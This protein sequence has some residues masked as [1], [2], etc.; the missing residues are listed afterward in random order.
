MGTKIQ[1]VVVVLGL[2]ITLLAGGAEI[3]YTGADATRPAELSAAGNWSGGAV[4]GAE[5]I[6]VIDVAALG[7]DVVELTLAVDWQVGGIRLENNDR[8]L[9]LAPAAG[10]ASVPVLTLGASGYTN[11][12]TAVSLENFE[13]GLA[14]RIPLATACE[15]T[16]DVGYQNF[17]TYATVSGSATLTIAR[18]AF[19]IHHAALEYGGKIVY[20]GPFPSPNWTRT[21]SVRAYSGGRWAAE[22]ENHTRCFLALTN[23]TTWSTLFAN[24]FVKQVAGNFGLMVRYHEDGNP[25]K[26]QG[27]LAFTDGDRFECTGGTTGGPSQ[28]FLD[29]TGG[30]WI[31]NGPAAVGYFDYYFGTWYPYNYRAIWTIDGGLLRAGSAFAGRY[32]TDTSTNNFYRF[33]QRGGDVDLV[34]YLGVGGGNQGNANS[35]GEYILR[36]GVLNI[37]TNAAGQTGTFGLKLMPCTADQTTSEQQ[38]VYTQTGGEARAPRISVG[39]DRDTNNR[40]FEDHY[41]LFDLK[42]GTF[43]L[44][45]HGFEVAPYWNVASTNG[46][47]TLRFSG[48]TLRAAE[49]FAT[50]CPWTIAPG[51]G[52]TL[53]TS[54]NV[55]RVFAPVWGS[56]TLVKEGAGRAVLTDATRFTGT[57]DVRE[58]VVE[59]LGVPEE[60]TSVGTDGWIWR[61][62]TL[63]GTY[64]ADDEVTSWTDDVHG[65]AAV[66]NAKNAGVN[67]QGKAYG[68]GNPTLEE[69]SL[70]GHA[71][72]VFSKA[73]LAVPAEANPL[74]G[75]STNTLVV[76]YAPSQTSSGD[77]FSALYNA[78]LLGGA[79]GNWGDCYSL[80][81]YGGADLAGFARF[82]SGSTKAL[83]PSSEAVGTGD[84]R[85]H[86]AI[87]VTEGTRVVLY[88]D[89]LR[90]TNVLTVAMRPLFDNLPLNIG[91]AYPDEQN[92]RGLTGRIAEVRAYD[93]ALSDTDC[94][95]LSRTLLETYNGSVDAVKKADGGHLQAVPGAVATVAPATPPETD[96]SWSADTLALADGAV[97]TAWPNETGTRTATR[98][99]A[100]D[101]VSAGP[102]FVKDALNGR[103]ALRF[104]R[105]GKTALAL[106]AADAPF[107]GTLD[108]T[109]AVVFRTTAPGVGTTAWAADRDCCNLIGG[110][111]SA[112]TGS[113][114]IS[115]RE[116]GT[117]V[118][119]WGKT[120][121]M[122]RK[123]FR[124]DDGLPHV[125]V[126]A[127]DAGAGVVRWMV[128]GIPA[129]WTTDD[130]T[131]LGRSAVLVGAL[132]KGSDVG[133]FEGDIAAFR[134]YDRALAEDEM[135]A[136]SD[137]YGAQYG[138]GLAGRMAAD[139]GELDS[140]GL[141]ART[142]RVAAGAT[143]RLPVSDAAPFTVAAGHTLA[144]K[145]TVEGTLRLADGATLEVDAEDHAGAR[146]EA[147]LVPSGTVTLAFTHG[148]VSLRSWQP[149]F[150]VGS[151][152]IGPGVVWNVAGHGR[153]STCEVRD[154]IFGIR[155][156]NGTFLLIR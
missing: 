143:L 62:D 72:L 36:G 28:G 54:T 116:E 8:L 57:L 26:L 32:C 120:T 106:P 145:G 104:S 44:G 29:M 6:A 151:A 128:D 148:P 35:W 65:V 136:L 47:Y 70:N 134:L 21:P 111:L 91:G 31:S 52:F 149:L 108:F 133:F 155:S 98:D 97:V 126:L 130:L 125:A 3:A 95:A 61:A 5:D 84:R 37:A 94:V 92:F 23:D 100:G 75:L 63:V 59:V 38:G 68:V 43:N 12:V 107:D 122:L 123:P 79:N 141:G 13:R 64:A 96:A 88:S 34:N 105:A 87:G 22:L 153:A 102:T 101:A 154:G 83:A 135:R 33:E 152:T 7:E 99:E 86:V 48:G 138:F 129:T 66:P 119:S 117:A 4:P 24:R 56:G 25:E 51:D 39:G 93:R 147:L 9:T 19:I 53:D 42:G 10:A 127:R 146:V 156:V 49:S 14:V 144:V 118:G 2:G 20:A 55:V 81:A 80:L 18:G 124:L 46:A 103:A 76:V 11:T 89:G 40:K 74:A 132:A 121:R 73:C 78:P 110:D 137:W 60:G 77:E 112:T 67:N 131:A 114:A 27:R 150:P 41:T 1:A 109:A 113:F 139:Y 90:T 45:R 115:L 58:G 17:V 71:A 16:W 140:R 15:Q 69:E 85:A 50:E 30:T 82:Q 142:V